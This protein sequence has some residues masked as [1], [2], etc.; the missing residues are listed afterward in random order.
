MKYFFILGFI[1]F[2]V[3][4]CASSP[5][6]QGSHLTFGM[7]KKHVI[8]SETSQE[9]VLRLFGAPNIITQQSGKHETWTYEKVAYDASEHSGGVGVGAGGIVGTTLL[10]GVGSFSSS[11][12]SSGTRTMTLMIYFDKNEKVIDYSMMETHY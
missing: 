9:E 7:V 12:S 2:F 1:F 8:K 11:K 4:S 6:R 3:S 5:P 10:G